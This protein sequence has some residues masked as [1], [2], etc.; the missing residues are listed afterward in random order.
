MAQGC[1]DGELVELL[2]TAPGEPK[3]WTQFLSHLTVRLKASGAGFM[4]HHPSQRQY[5]IDVSCQLPIESFPPYANYYGAIDPWFRSGTN[6]VAGMV[7][8][9]SSFCPPSAFRETE[10]YNDFLR[11]YDFFY[12]CGVTLE[13]SNGNRTVLSLLRTNRQPDFLDSD[14]RLLIDL[15]PHLRRALSLHRKM[16]D[17]RQTATASLH[18]LDSFDTGVIGVQAD[19][20][21]SFANQKAEVILHTGH[22][23]THISGKLRCK[24]SAQESR[25]RELLHTAASPSFSR[26]PGGLIL[27]HGKQLLYVSVFPY[28]SQERVLLPRPM[29]LLILSDPETRP[30]SREHLLKTLFRLSPAE[31]RLSML[32]M[33]GFDISEIAD[34]TQTTVGTVRFRLKEIYKKTGVKRQSRLIRLLSQ[35]PGHS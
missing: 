28:Y 25:F 7:A 14:I 21:V 32:F 3:L 11:K 6:R 34:Q 27:R 33:Q 23:F 1:N 12:Q 17:L 5:G 26:I 2:Y 29:A 13:N 16:I 24:D 19:G 31:I 18:A 10:F 8:S 4:V 22:F 30:Q 20:T 9:G 35:L 15:V